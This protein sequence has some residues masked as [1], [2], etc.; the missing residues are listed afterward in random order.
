MDLVRLK[1]DATG[2]REGEAKWVEET[3]IKLYNAMASIINSGVCEYFNRDPKWEGQ[4]F[5]EGSE[6]MITYGELM[7][8][9]ADACSK[10]FGVKNGRI[11]RL[12][13]GID[14][15]LLY[16]SKEKIG[17]DNVYQGIIKCK[18]EDYKLT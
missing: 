18:V 5:E 10:Q 7:M 17:N 9:I 8:G 4:S 13:G 11:I 15:L 2:V 3:A 16:P 14:C 12:C 1:T 6:Y